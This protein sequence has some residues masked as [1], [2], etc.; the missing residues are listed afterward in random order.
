V[1]GVLYHILYSI[2]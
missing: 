1:H 2:I